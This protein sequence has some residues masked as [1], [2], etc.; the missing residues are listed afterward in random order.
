ME[1]IEI[2][3]NLVAFNTIN[4]KE[5]IDIVKWIEDY[6]KKLDFKCE[7]IYD[8][9]RK[10]VNLIATI[11]SDYNLAFGGHLDTVTSDENWDTNP[12]EL[13]V[14][15]QKAYGLGV[16]DMKG[17]IAAVL[18]SCS[19]IDRKK[20]KKGLVLFFTFDEEYGFGGIKLL[21]EKN[22][23][24]PKHIV[25][26]EPT[27]LK[28]IIATKGCLEFT[29]TFYGKSAHSSNPKKGEN[30]IIEATKF[31]AELNSFSEE[32]KKEKNRLFSIPYTTI[33]IGVIN[34][35]KTVNMVP[36]KC[37]IKFDARTVA[38]SHNTMI[39]NTIKRMLRKYK[40]IFEVNMDI[41]VCIN[42][43]NN[44]ISR[45]E[46]IC[47]NEKAGENYVTEASFIK[48]SSTVILGVGPISSHQSNEYIELK[49]L[50]KTVEVYKKIIEEYC[51]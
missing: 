48:D 4:D 27:D 7:R 3:K 16:C 24:F 9:E 37:I 32:L 38:K 50:D 6:L 36:D 2:L 1:T 41:D 26:A 10:K 39:K 47:D 45:I 43:N 44:M 29:V 5:N 8:E 19:E 40:C 11:G 28:P 14:N 33:N 30:A 22:F 15:K 18:K 21:N 23:N 42:N 12:L 25:L 17:G 13:R 34:G 31:I 49:K 20:L 35:G 51:Y 46:Q